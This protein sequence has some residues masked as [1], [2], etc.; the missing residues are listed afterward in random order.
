MSSVT[1]FLPLGREPW[2]PEGILRSCWAVGRRHV[3]IVEDITHERGGIGTVRCEWTPDR[4]EK[5]NKIE[6]RQYRAGRAAHYQQ[7][8][9]ILGKSILCAEL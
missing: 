7:I 2:P 6:W 4:P 9:N 5:L 8:A 1:I 3:S